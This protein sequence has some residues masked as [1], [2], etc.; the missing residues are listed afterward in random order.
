MFRMSVPENP[1]RWD[2]FKLFSSQW[3]RGLEFPTDVTK[4]FIEEQHD[5]KFFIKP[6]VWYFFLNR[7]LK[8]LALKT[9]AQ[10]DHSFHVHM[11]IVAHNAVCLHEVG[12]H[13]SLGLYYDYFLKCSQLLNVLYNLKCCLMLLSPKESSWYFPHL[14]ILYFH[15]LWGKASCC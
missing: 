6:L 13:I 12:V 10:L 7:S 14:F 3:C 5:I 9:S 11:Q 8:D 1:Q 4:M 15:F 2:G